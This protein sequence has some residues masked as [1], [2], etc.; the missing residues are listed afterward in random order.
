MVFLSLTIMVLLG[1]TGLSYDLGRR[2][3]VQGELQT[4]VDSA[5]LAAVYRLDGTRQGIEKAN[6]IALSG[7]IGTRQ[8]SRYNF[9]STAV[10]GTQVAYATSLDGPYVDYATASFAASNDYAF[11]RVTSSAMV[12]MSFAPALRGIPKTT[13][14]AATA[15]AGQAARTS[16]NYGGISPFMPDSHDITD[17]ANFGFTPAGQYTLKWGNGNSGNGKGKGSSSGP[18][19][20]TCANDIGWPNPN[21]TSQ[22][23]FVDIGQ[24]NSNSNL[25]TAIMS[26]NYPNA[27]SSP[28]SLYVGMTL[29][30]VPGNRGSSIFDALQERVNQDTNTA[31]TTYSQYLATGTGNGRRIITVPIAD[32]NTW[33]GNGNGTAVVAGFANFFLHTSYS[34][35]SG[36][37]CALYVGPA[38]LNGSSSGRTDSTKIYYNV[39]YR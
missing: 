13:S 5:A 16:A 24:G 28:S 26:G 8:P 2:F 12:P 4:Y 33:S 18:P 30:G 31:S 9:G 15:T 22:H 36:P 34:G 37:I 19:E 23:G 25:R 39:L 3:V 38:S 7:P 35:T 27:S 6:V 29:G 1:A 10:A 17:T 20:T 11:V 14:V 32:P 21:P